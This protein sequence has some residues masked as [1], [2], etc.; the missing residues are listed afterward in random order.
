M[1]TARAEAVEL[2]P[3]GLDGEAVTGSDFFLQFFNFAIFEFN[4]LP[5]ARADQV[6][7]MTLVGDIVVLSLRAEMPCLRDAG[8]TKQV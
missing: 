2:E 1:T 6:I 5:A 4:N 3:V 8:V 7:V